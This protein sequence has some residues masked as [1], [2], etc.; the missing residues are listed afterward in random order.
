MTVLGVSIALAGAL[1]RCTLPDQAP[2]PAAFSTK[3]KSPRGMLVS[4][5]AEK[6]DHAALIASLKAIGATTVIIDAS[7][8][9]TGEAVAD[10]V[11]LAIE[12]QQALGADDAEILIG[13][14]RA[15]AHEGKPM[16]DLAMLDAAFSACYPGGPSLS[17]SSPISEKLRLCS[18][19]ISQKI[20]DALTA[21]NA[22]PH[23]G[24]YI[25]HEPELTGSL[26]DV[27]R[28]ALIALLHDSASACTAVNRNVAYST[29]LTARSGDPNVAARVL[30]DL[31]PATG[32]NHVLV[33]DGVATT[34]D[35]GASRAAIYY[36]ALRT[37]TV[38]RLPIVNVWA[39]VES[40]DCETAACERTR[41]TSSDRFRRQVCG[42]QNRVEVMV[43][44][45]FLHDFA[46][47]S[48]SDASVDADAA[49]VDAQT[50]IDD[51]DASAQLRSGYLAWADGGAPCP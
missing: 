2:P 47:R 29:L 33:R 7:A 43:A 48:F 38:D 36:Q 44:R 10:R 31:L 21:A 40:F 12:L 32:V 18:Q 46:E 16:G 45:E 8:D 35:A 30:R 49:D 28:K 4:L 13:T 14:Y 34:P 42:A 51:T 20:A 24:C 19:A 22:S 17:A 3:V 41:P 9:A 39:D 6:V 5:P 23:I 15:R 11:A 1:V 50:L 37:A 26:N 27:E 25:T